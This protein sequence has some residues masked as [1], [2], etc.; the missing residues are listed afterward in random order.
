VRILI[1]YCIILFSAELAAG[2]INDSLPFA[3]KSRFSLLYANDVYNGT[4]RY[5]T[6]YIQLAYSGPFSIRKFK[7]PVQYEYSL[8]QNV[9][10][11]SDI[12]SDTIQENDRPYAALLFAKVQKNFYYVER[13]MFAKAHASLGMTGRHAFGEDMQR[14]IHYAVNS[15]QALGW[16]HQLKDAPYIQAG[17]LIEKGLLVLRHFEFILNGKANTGTVFNDLSMGH[18]TRFNIGNPYFFKQANADKRA[19]RFYAQIKNDLKFTAFNG[20]LQGALTS[21]KNPYVLQRDQIKRFV[22]SSEACISFT[23]GKLG[24]EISE[25]FISKEFKTGLRHSWGHMMFSY[26]IRNK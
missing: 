2:N 26:I 21:R 16:R 12:F 24:I 7:L 9:Y 13:N 5:L 8:Q 15:R 20:T 23:Y 18:A 22:F 1:L 6:Q 4:D 25:T 19:F 11:P 10:T 14:E 3:Q 17:L